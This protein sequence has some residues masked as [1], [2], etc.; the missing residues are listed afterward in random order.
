MI[1]KICFKCNV[2]KPLSEFYKHKKMS[3]G[4]LNKCKDCTKKDT[5]SRTD[6]LSENPEWVEKEK[7]R[8]RQKYYR[9]NY[10]GKHKPTYE[11]KKITTEKYNK[12]YPEKKESRG[13]TSHLKPIVEGNHLH[14]WSYNKEHY[15]DVIEL[16]KE[17]HNKA[18]RYMIY[19]Q[20]RMM[21]RRTDN[22]ALLDT[23]E[24]HIEYIEIIKTKP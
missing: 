24:S 6:I 20:E 1:N 23:R 15:K 10:R 18:H 4:H 8:N 21:Y 19:D 11:Q 14:H 13:Y 12:M 16:S 17:L 9:L 3:D 7:T 2:N 22:N 5:K